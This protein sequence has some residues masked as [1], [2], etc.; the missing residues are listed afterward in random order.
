MAR[1]GEKLAAPT[2]ALLDAEEE[3]RLRAM[4][5]IKDK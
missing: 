3:K 5:Y 1:L 2:P 4:G